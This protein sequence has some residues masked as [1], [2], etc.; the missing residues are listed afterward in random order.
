MN[1]PWIEVEHEGVLRL[2]R[3]RDATHIDVQGAG[4]HL[5]LSRENAHDQLRSLWKNG[6]RIV[7]RDQQ[8]CD[9]AWEHPPPGRLPRW[10]HYRAFPGAGLLI[11][12]VQSSK[13]RITENPYIV[14][15]TPAEGCRHFV[16]T[17]VGA[18]GDKDNLTYD[19]AIRPALDHDCGCKAHANRHWCRHV[20]S[21]A[22]LCADGTIAP[23][24]LFP[25]EKKRGTTA[26]ESVPAPVAA[27]H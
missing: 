25:R 27:N 5:V 10:M 4:L 14:T 21:L 26:A 17:K 13:K 6:A 3:V 15:E 2:A 16:L 20:N 19:V 23:G 7:A 22:K 8:G 1:A 24:A 9:L 18:H 11:V 12:Y